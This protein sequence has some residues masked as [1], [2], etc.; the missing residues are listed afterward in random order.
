MVKFSEI[1]HVRDVFLSGTFSLSASA[2]GADN[3]VG[4]PLGNLNEL[5]PCQSIVRLEASGCHLTTIVSDAYLVESLFRNFAFLQRMDLSNNQLRDD[6]LSQLQRL[7][8]LSI[9][10]LNGNEISSVNG[11][12]VLVSSLPKLKE[13]DV[14]SN[15]V[16]HRVGYSSLP[17]ELRAR[18]G[19]LLQRFDGLD[20]NLYAFPAAVDAAEPR[21][22][23]RSS[24]APASHGSQQGRQ[25]FPPQASA[26]SASS[27]SAARPAAARATDYRYAA[28]PEPVSKPLDT[29]FE[30]LRPSNA[31][32]PPSDRTWEQLL[33]SEARGSMAVPL[34]SNRYAA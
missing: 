24:I 32:P 5:L 28:Q 19:N 12:S 33:F 30:V 26:A 31:G 2:S 18:P 7:Q 6:A 11:I 27:S 21:T 1:S 3:V 20:I 8:S 4:T 25:V 29:S 22:P 14:R 13:I 17:A 9:L 10:L 16:N 15:P 34:T 23:E